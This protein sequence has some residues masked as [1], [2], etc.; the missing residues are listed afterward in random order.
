MT[1]KNM[2]DKAKVIAMEYPDVKLQCADGKVYTITD[3]EGW[4]DY[5]MGGEWELEVEKTKS[6]PLPCKAVVI[7]MEYPRV[8]LKTA[9]GTKV[10]IKVR[11]GW[12]NIKLGDEWELEKN[13]DAK[14]K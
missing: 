11:E 4:K 13:P 5:E 8:T 14:P 10:T 2:R 9:D 3:R 12:D 6:V 1:N 7:A